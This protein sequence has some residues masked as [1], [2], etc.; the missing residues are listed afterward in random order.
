M[1][2]RERERQKKSK[3]KRSQNETIQCQR[4]VQYR[5]GSPRFPVVVD[6]QAA[7]SIFGRIGRQ[8]ING[9]PLPRRTV[10]MCSYRYAGQ[11]LKFLPRQRRCRRK[12]ILCLIVPRRWP[13]GCSAR[14]SF[15]LSLRLSCIPRILSLLSGPPLFRVSAIP[16][17]SITAQVSVRMHAECYLAEGDFMAVFNKTGEFRR[18]VS[19]TKPLYYRKFY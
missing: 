11:I 5:S 8:S 1:K 7:R 6:R 19:M 14:F 15:P 16:S 4:I 13:R 12:R 2:K 18:R 3:R 9:H 17:I 10:P